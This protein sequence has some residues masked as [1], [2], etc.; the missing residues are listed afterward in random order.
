MADTTL[1]AEDASA[2]FHELLGHK[3]ETEVRAINPNK[4]APIKSEFAHSKK[5]FVSICEKNNHTKNVYAGLNERKKGG[6][7]QEDVISLNCIIVDI[8]PIR[9][10][11]PQDEGI[12]DEDLAGGKTASTD[13]ELAKAIAKGKE[14]EKH[15]KEFG[16]EIGGEEMSGNG[17]QLL[18]PLSPAIEIT[19]GNRSAIETNLKQFGLALGEKFNDDEVVIDPTVYEIARIAKVPGTLS[20]KGKNL[21]HRPHRVA[22]WLNY[23]GPKKN[24]RLR[25][26]LLLETANKEEA[27]N[28]E[29]LVIPM[30]IAKEIERLIKNGVLITNSKGKIEAGNR[31]YSYLSLFGVLSNQGYDRKQIASAIQYLN[32]AKVEHPKKFEDVAIEIEQI[33]YSIR[34]EVSEEK[35]AEEAEKL[36]KDLSELLKSEEK[37]TGAKAAAVHLSDTDDAAYS[38]KLVECPVDIAGLGSV[39]HIPNRFS[40]ES[41]E[42]GKFIFT[43]ENWNGNDSAT[44]PYDEEGKRKAEIYRRGL[45]D[46]PKEKQAT[47]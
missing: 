26:R 20:I 13:E 31:H 6:T 29:P 36:Q 10:R 8:D 42:K 9:K 15:L 28:S 39:Y 44:F 17:S 18:I 40:V 24:D 16:I 12:S 47:R 32:K 27:R 2:K 14:V 1:N 19:D 11:T 35:F 38:G 23:Y 3:K 4:E 34:S 46:C 33:K 25:E 22:S 37:E 30:P 41:E 5:E 43:V 45:I 7:K 21:P